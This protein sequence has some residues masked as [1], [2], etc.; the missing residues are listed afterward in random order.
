MSSRIKPS[1][2]AFVVVLNIFLG[3][4]WYQRADA[5]KFSGTDRP[6]VWT[7][8]LS[9]RTA[10]DREQALQAAFPLADFE[11]KPLDEVREAVIPRPVKWFEEVV[12]ST[13]FDNPFVSQP[14]RNESKELVSSG[15][16]RFAFKSISKVSYES[17]ERQALNQVL[18][19]EKSVG[20]DIYMSQS[21]IEVPSSGLI[22]V[23]KYLIELKENALLSVQKAVHLNGKAQPTY[24]VG[25]PHWLVPSRKLMVG[26]TWVQRG[27]LTEG[28]PSSAPSTEA[29]RTLSRVVIFEGRLAAEIKSI[30]TTYEYVSVPT[31]QYVSHEVKTL[32]YLDLETGEPL[33]FETKSDGEWQSKSVIRGCNQIFVKHLIQTKQEN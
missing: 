15:S 31:T 16:R 8:T 11:I 13:E 6:H 32:S 26:E 19:R 24:E 18:V 17:E 14:N 7:L 4:A 22:S 1:A 30:A 33:W 12:L 25:V 3:Y 5:P 23:G 27:V 21:G 2:I 29:S 28:M 9:E 10:K 20:L